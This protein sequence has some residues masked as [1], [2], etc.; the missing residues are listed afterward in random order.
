M[1]PTILSLHERANPFTD[2]SGPYTKKG[3]EASGKSKR[4]FQIFALSKSLQAGTTSKIIE[5]FL[6]I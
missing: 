6:K 3:G 4:A 5:G 1:G 2:M